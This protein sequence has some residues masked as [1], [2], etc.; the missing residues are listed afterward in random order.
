MGQP[1]EWTRI[2]EEFN[3]L[4]GPESQRKPRQCRER[5]INVVD[6]SVKRTKWRLEEDL[7]IL[8]LW[9]NMGKKWHEISQKVEGRTEIQVKNR[10]NCLIKKDTPKAGS[11]NLDEQVNNLIDN[12]NYMLLS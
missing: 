1:K 2:C 10:F 7:Q 6:P 12:L 9:R 3:K 4:V 5:W 11:K 8:Q